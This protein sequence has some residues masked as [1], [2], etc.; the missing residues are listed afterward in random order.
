MFRRPGGDPAGENQKNAD[1][2]FKS[3]HLDFLIPN[4][5]PRISPKT[6]STGSDK[7]RSAITVSADGPNQDRAGDHQDQQKAG[8]RHQP[9]TEVPKSAEK[10]MPPAGFRFGVFRA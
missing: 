1:S 3:V 7:N 10:D 6:K 8:H 4:D 9:S 5:Y 2:G